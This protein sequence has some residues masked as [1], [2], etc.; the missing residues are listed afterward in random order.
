M[1]GLKAKRLQVLHKPPVTTLGTNFMRH[2]MSFER[3]GVLRQ[4]YLGYQAATNQYL[5]NESLEVL[6]YKK[7][8]DLHSYSYYCNVI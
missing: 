2:S 7:H 4:N 3:N 5:T 6:G 1:S 8:I